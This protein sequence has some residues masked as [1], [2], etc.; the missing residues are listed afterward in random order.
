M[1]VPRRRRLD[2]LYAAHVTLVLCLGAGRILGAHRGVGLAAMLAG[3]AALAVILGLS[4]LERRDGKVLLLFAALLAALVS[5]LEP[6]A[7][8]L[9]YAGLAVLLAALWVLHGR[10]SVPDRPIPPPGG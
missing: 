1:A 6:D 8:D 10:R 9:V 5:R 2:A 4:F 7:L 3:V